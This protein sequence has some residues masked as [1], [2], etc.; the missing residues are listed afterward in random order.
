MAGGFDDGPLG[1]GKVEAL[2]VGDG[3][4]GAGRAAGG[5]VHAGD[6]VFGGEAPLGVEGVEIDGGGMGVGEVGEGGEVVN[7]AVGEEVGDDDGVG[8]ADVAEEEGG[9]IAGINDDGLAGL[10]VGDEVA[11]FFD[12]AGDMWLDVH[13]H[14]GYKSQ[15]DRQ[16]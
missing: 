3:M 15:G 8:V 7:M 11:I 10:G 5:G 12:K 2:V 16:G 13:G 6:A 9:V 14:E 1:A 4:D